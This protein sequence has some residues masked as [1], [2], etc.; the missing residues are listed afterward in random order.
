MM[1]SL[2]CGQKNRLA[3]PKV[4][5]IKVNKTLHALNNVFS[6]LKPRY[7]SKCLG[8]KI[9]EIRKTSILTAFIIPIEKL[10]E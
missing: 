5:Q 3:A 2:N 9:M 10:L 1:N 4:H 6:W 8:I 7:V